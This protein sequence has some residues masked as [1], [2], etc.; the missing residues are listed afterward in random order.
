MID[1]RIVVES[2]RVTTFDVDALVR[3]VRAMVRSLRARNADLFAVAD[4]IAA[5]RPMSGSMQPVDLVIA[6]GLLVE[7]GAHRRAINRGR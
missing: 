3:E 1:G 2:G 6:G 7:P 5:A 4:D